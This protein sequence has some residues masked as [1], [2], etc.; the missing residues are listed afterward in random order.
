MKK[1]ISFSF[2][3]IIQLAVIS[4]AYNSGIRSV[5]EPKP[6][7]VWVTEQQVTE[8]KSV[9]SLLSV[10]SNTTKENNFSSICHEDFRGS[11]CTIADIKR[12]VCLQ[13]NNTLAK[14]TFYLEKDEKSFEETRNIWQ[15]IVS[16]GGGL[17]EFIKYTRQ[18]KK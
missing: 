8:L 16:K 3:L 1:I 10:D 15:N 4:I 12:L 18:N 7:V 13:E 14:V 9:M 11:P 5:P 17:D 6:Q 2:I